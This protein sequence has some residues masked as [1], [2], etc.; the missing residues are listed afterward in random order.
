[1]SASE[2]DRKELG[3]V[4][5]VNCI[6]LI[7]LTR[8]VVEEMKKTGG[9]RI[10]VDIDKNIADF[11]IASPKK[12]PAV[13]IEP[14]TAGLGAYETLASPD[15]QSEPSLELVQPGATRTVEIRYTVENH[16]G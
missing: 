3:N 7:L 13:C 14:W 11:I 15:W 5:N 16:A 2:I 6:G 12:T 1:M 10:H 4:F 8:R 9:R